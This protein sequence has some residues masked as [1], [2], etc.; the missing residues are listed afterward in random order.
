VVIRRQF[1][2]CPY[3]VHNAIMA[4]SPIVTNTAAIGFVASALML[5]AFG[6]KDMVSLR[7]V[8]ICSNIA[9]IAYGFMSARWRVV[10]TSNAY[11][12]PS[13]IR[14]LKF[15]FQTGNLPVGLALGRS[16]SGTRHEGEPCTHAG[17]SDGVPRRSGG[18]RDLTLVQLD[19]SRSVLTGP[20]P[21]P[22]PA[23]ALG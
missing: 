16:P 8:A 1:D 11:G 10:R 6:M 13:A 12:A 17:N 3:L 14:L 7:I 4:H 9:F 18:R 19:C 20:R 2:R 21:R 23:S 5:A 22:A 15:K